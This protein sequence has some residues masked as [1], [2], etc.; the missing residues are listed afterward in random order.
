MKTIVRYYR[1]VVLALLLGVIPGTV[2]A[3]RPVNEHHITPGA[4]TQDKGEIST[5]TFDFKNPRMVELNVPGVGKRV[6]WYMCYWLSNYNKEPFTVYPE[7][8]LMTNRNTLHH[9]EVIPEIQEAIRKIEDP[10]NRFHFENSVTIGKT[11]IPVSKPDALPRRI[12]G[13]AIWT[14]VNEKAPTTSK[15]RVFATGLSNG[16]HIDD[17]GQISRKTLM[18]EFERR[19]DGSR[20]DSNEI[21]YND[22]FKWIYRDASSAEVD[23]KPPVSVGPPPGK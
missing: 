10:S 13:I 11:P 6:V 12:A 9:D 2:F 18:L 4:N 5:I 3:Q 21:V 23:M 15:F 8:L 22:V 1:Q 7:F 17:A 16:W 14:D 20:I 19:G